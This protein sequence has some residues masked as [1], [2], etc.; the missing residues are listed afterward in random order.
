MR[1]SVQ[2]ITKSGYRLKWRRWR[3]FLHQWY[4]HK[5]HSNTLEGMS[6]EAQVKMVISFVPYC[7]A[8]FRLGARTL[9]YHLSAIRWH[10][11]AQLA[12][13]AVFDHRAIK[14]LRTGLTLQDR[15]LGIQS[16]NKL[17]TSLSMCQ[18]IWEAAKAPECPRIQRMIAFAQCLSFL[19]M[20]RAS[21]YTRPRDAPSN[22]APS[23]KQR[24]IKGSD[25]DHSTASQPRRKK[26]KQSV[27][28]DHGIRAKAV[29]F[30]CSVDGLT[31]CVT[32]AQLQEA[33]HSTIPWT[34]VLS[35]RLLFPGCKRDINRRGTPF[36]FDT[37]DYAPPFDEFTHIPWLCF[38]WARSAS[39]SSG[40]DLF[41]SY[42]SS[43]QPSGRYNLRPTDICHQLRRTAAAAGF[44]P[45]DCLRFSAHSNR[46]GG[47]CTA[48]NSGASSELIMFMGKWKSLSTS[49]HY[50][51]AAKGTMRAVSKLQQSTAFRSGFTATDV[52]ELN[53]R[54]AGFNSQYRR[55]RLSPVA[56]RVT[57]SAR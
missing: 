40:E 15:A 20:L 19:L 27:I 1:G 48:F 16:K 26:P 50:Q 18:S 10:F 32:A 28:N 23:Q 39:F 12:D 5:R 8:K 4:G 42:P 17:P 35:V 49:L 33:A 30:T 2:P 22:A 31:R 13:T 7:Q 6:L 3:H 37:E 56:R 36:I 53:T 25:T 52:R 45:E 34:S 24:R 46:Y 41:F 38:H 55:K 54:P 47:A 43:Q 11:G 57:A 51:A 9:M 21:E 44:S 14:S 29:E